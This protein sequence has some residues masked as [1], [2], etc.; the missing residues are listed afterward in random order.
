MIDRYAIPEL[1]ELFGERHKL[2]LWLRIELLG[3]EGLH[4][5]GIVPDA[6]WEQIQ[7]AVGE[8]DAGASEEGAKH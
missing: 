2:E 6:D 3:A 1:Q 4:A 5:A 8:V 7:V